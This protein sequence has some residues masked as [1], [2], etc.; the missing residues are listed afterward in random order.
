MNIQTS[1]KLGNAI[2]EAREKLGLTQKQVG[3]ILGI[4]S[5]GVMISSI[6]RGAVKIP[7][8]MLRPLCI[9]VKLSKKEVRSIFIDG[10]IEEIDQLLWVGK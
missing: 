7:D 8:A 2:R 6:E 3:E 4:P 9:T 5:G 10:A 1:N